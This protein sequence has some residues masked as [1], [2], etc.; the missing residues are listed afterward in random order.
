MIPTRNT[1]PIAVLWPWQTLNF[2]VLPLPYHC[3]N[4][5]YH[6][7]CTSLP[8]VPSVLVRASMFWAV[9]NFLPRPTQ[10]RSFLTS[11]RVYNAAVARLQREQHRLFHVRPRFDVFWPWLSRQV[12]SDQGFMLW[13]YGHCQYLHSYTQCGDQLQTSES[14]VCRRQILTTNVVH[15]AVRVKLVTVLVYTC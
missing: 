1:R 15:R 2:G 8:R 11:S 12:L 7:C 4:T 13:V 5:D 10:L 9:Q 3:R 14:A 6:V